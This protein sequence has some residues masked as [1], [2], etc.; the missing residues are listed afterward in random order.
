MVS[1]FDPRTG[2]D[3]SV[4]YALVTHPVSQSGLTSTRPKTLQNARN[5]MQTWEQEVAEFEMKYAKKDD[6]DAQ[7]LAL[8][9]IMPETVFGEAGVFRGKS[10]NLCS[11]LRTAVINY[12]DDKVPVSMMKQGPSIATT[13]MVQTMSTADQGEQG[14]D[15]VTQDE[16]FAMVQQY[17]KGKCKGKKRACWNCGGSD[18]YSRDCPND[19]QDNSW[20]DGGH[21]RFRKEARQAKM[22]A[23]DGT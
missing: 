5:T 9:S 19:K 7:I 8:K 16:I 18:H 2:A 20:T 14:E 15:E 21:G 12:L 17:R 4:V 22:Q 13:N 3:R 1:H 6:E 10:F 11:D 23:K